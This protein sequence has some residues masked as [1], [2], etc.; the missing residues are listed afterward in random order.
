MRRG[1]VIKLAVEPYCHNC[2]K[3]EANVEKQALID[4]SGKAIVETTVACKNAIMCVAVK[5]YLK[6]VII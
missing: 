2:P 5:E 1:T 6:E 3:F 4:C